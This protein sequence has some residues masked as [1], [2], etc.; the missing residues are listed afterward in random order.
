MHTG[1]A[2]N[3][4]PFR[5]VIPDKLET[6]LREKMKADRHKAVR[7]NLNLFDYYTKPWFLVSQTAYQI[8]VLLPLLQHLSVGLAQVIQSEEELRSLVIIAQA[9]SDFIDDEQKGSYSHVDDE[10]MD[11]LI[12][13]LVVLRDG[14][15]S[16]DGKTEEDQLHE[17]PVEDVGLLVSF[18]ELS[19]DWCTTRR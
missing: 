3:D 14:E 12:L 13:E 7:V 19:G 1:T 17:D 5:N 10:N 2:V 4:Y 18:A 9:G 11:W 16:E 15:Q 8:I 6:H